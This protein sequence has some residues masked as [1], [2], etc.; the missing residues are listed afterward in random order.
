MDQNISFLRR[1]LLDS[2]A[3]ISRNRALREA[4]GRWIAF[5]DSDDLWEKDKL[6]KQIAFMEER[7]CHFSFTDYR[8]VMPDGNPLPYI[9]TAPN[10]VTKFQLYLD[11]VEFQKK[12]YRVRRGEKK[13]KSIE[14]VKMQKAR[15]EA[16]AN[17]KQPP[18]NKKQTPPNTDGENP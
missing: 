15:K 16:A 4:T 10:K 12:M 1:T 9:Y 6:E 11:E 8:I 3:A 18:R 13:A 2:G 7:G 17:K 5:L 14:R